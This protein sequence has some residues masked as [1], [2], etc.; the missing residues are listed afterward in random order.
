MEQLQRR[1][2]IDTLRE[3]ATTDS[4]FSAS[5]APSF[6]QWFRLIG[7]FL[8]ITIR[9]KGCLFQVL[10]Q[11]HASAHTSK[12]RNFK[13]ITLYKDKSTLV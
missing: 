7:L 8:P 9:N 13:Y 5:E 3:V 2:E 11:K 12:C 10:G 6:I 4:L 1:M